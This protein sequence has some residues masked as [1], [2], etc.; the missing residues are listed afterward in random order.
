[1]KCC[2]I[3]TFGVKA[4][5]NRLLGGKKV[6]ANKTS[7]KMAKNGCI[8][9]THNGTRRLAFRYLS[10]FNNKCKTLRFEE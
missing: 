2:K 6:F 10:E 9:S 1:M 3:G 4:A 5:S 7:Y 8:W